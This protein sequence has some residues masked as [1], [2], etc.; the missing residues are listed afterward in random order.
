MAKGFVKPVNG[1]YE[2]ARCRTVKPVEEFPKQPVTRG[3][4]AWCKPCK[5]AAALAYRAAAQAQGPDEGW[6]ARF[7]SYV[8]KSGDCH[9]WTGSRKKQDGYGV[10]W[11]AGKLQRVH[12]IAW[13][14]A[15]RELPEWPMVLDHICRVRHCCNP[16]HLRVVPQRDNSSI[17]SIYG[18]RKSA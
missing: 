14:R 8:D 5:N 3:H 12:R 11:L 17:Y 15:G 18:L 9:I 7:D 13:M 1:F 16:D 10:F 2:C 6:E 4:G